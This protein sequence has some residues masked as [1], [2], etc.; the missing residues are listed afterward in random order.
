MVTREEADRIQA[1]DNDARREFYL[2]NYDE[3]YRYCRKFTRIT[4]RELGYRRYNEDDLIVQLYLDLDKLNWKSQACFYISLKCSSFYWEPFGGLT[5]RKEQGLNHSILPWEREGSLREY[6]FLPLDRVI[7]E[8][9]EDSG[10]FYQFFSTYETP[11]KILID[12]TTR[13]YTGE[14]ITELLS[15]FLTPGTRKVL[16]LY[17]EGVRN[18]D[19]ERELHVKNATGYIKQLQ[20]Q[21][22]SHFPEVRARLRA[23]HIPIPR[24]L[25]RLAPE[26]QE[27]AA[28]EQEKLNARHRAQGDADR[29]ARGVPPA[30]RYANE[31]ER[32]RALAEKSRQQY[33]ARRQSE[34][35]KQKLKEYRAR[36]NAKMREKLLSDPEL[37]EAFKEK[38]RQAYRAACERKKAAA[39]AAAT[40]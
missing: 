16:P 12:K 36:A 19:I 20:G 31:E 17:L 18:V 3:L 6:D 10:E 1:G 26:L 24:Y 14:E 22:L 5:Q 25:L 27:K 29:R 28:E 39:A 32:R 33:A 4:N 13:H 30:F 40:S 37:Y 23:A 8:D 35:G 38:R 34:E 21:L 2:R 9:E 15:D 7:N 11:E